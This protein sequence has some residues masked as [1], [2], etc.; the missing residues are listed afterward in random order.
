MLDGID[1][2]LSML[3]MSRTITGKAD[4]KKQ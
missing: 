1:G 3:E 4:S 2:A